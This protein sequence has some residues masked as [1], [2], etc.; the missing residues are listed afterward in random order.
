VGAWFA[1]F[2][3]RAAL[4]W[5][6]GLEGIG[7]AAAVLAAAALGAWASIGEARELG[8]MGLEERRDSHMGWIALVGGTGSVACLFLPLPWGVAGAV[9]VL[10]VTISLWRSV[11]SGTGPAPAGGAARPLR[12]RPRP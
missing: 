9:V 11:A 7:V 4:N 3:M 12:D 8:R 1:A 10:V 6:L 2:V 5:I